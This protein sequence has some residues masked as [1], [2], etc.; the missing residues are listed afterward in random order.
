MRIAL[1][2]DVAVH[3]LGVD[4]QLSGDRSAWPGDCR[5]AASPR[6]AGVAPT[7]ARYLTA[8]AKVILNWL[9]RAQRLANL[10]DKG[11]H[12]LRHTF[13]SHLAMRGVPARA[14]QELAGHV[15]LTTTQRYMHL[16]PAAL[17]SAIRML[18]QPP[19][20]GHEAPRPV[21]QSLRFGDILET[22]RD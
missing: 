21:D 12:T 16:T 9:L 15:H 1:S 6:T 5:S 14:I 22:G 7:S 8:T 10:R 2:R 4:R 11:P 3:G 19:P 17:E 20:A 13:C 18:E